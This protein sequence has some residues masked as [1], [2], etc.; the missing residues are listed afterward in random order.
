MS[1]LQPYCAFKVLLCP[2]EAQSRSWVSSGNLQVIARFGGRTA[3]ASVQW[4]SMSAA[5]WAAQLCC[6][7]STN[8]A[9]PLPQ[10][11]HPVP[12]LL[13]A[14]HLPIARCRWRPKLRQV[15]SLT[16]IPFPRNVELCAR[17]AT[18]VT[19]PRDSQ[20]RV[21]VTIIPGPHASDAHKKHL[22][23]HPGKLCPEDFRAQFSRILKEVS[24]SP[25]SNHT[26][27]AVRIVH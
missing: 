21:E 19:S 26:W 15:V 23:Y 2:F 16:K 20:S 4:T 17:Y 27:N 13:L 6:V 5:L 25:N 8:S 18:Q 10:V 11:K 24:P 7:R 9:S 3:L 22:E 14:T 12:P 1:G